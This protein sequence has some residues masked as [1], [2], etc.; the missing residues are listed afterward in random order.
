MEYESNA[1]KWFSLHKTQNKTNVKVRSLLF[2]VPVSLTSNYCRS[3][4]AHNK[5]LRRGER[6]QAADSAENFLSL[7]ALVGGVFLH[8]PQDLFEF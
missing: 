5:A 7:R 3:G 4:S 2:L 8:S 6:R 1:I